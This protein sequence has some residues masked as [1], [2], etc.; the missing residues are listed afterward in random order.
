MKSLKAG[1]VKLYDANPETLNALSGTKL[2]VSIMVPN[3][4][5][6]KI[7]SNQS[8]A[9][10][11]VQNNVVPFYPAT[12]IRFLLVGNEILSYF[13]DQDKQTWL[14]L[15][16]A[17]YR[18]RSALRS[19][20]IRKIKVGTPLAMDVLQSS[21]P[22]S[23][24]TF[25]NDISSVVMEPLLRFLSQSQSFFFLDAYPYF[26][27]SASPGDISL[28]Y[29]L[30][31][32]GNFT[33]TDP[34]SRLTYTNLFDQMLDSVN[35]AMTRLGFS[36]IGL[37]ISETGWPTAGDIEQIGANIYN[38]AT[39]NRN[40]IRRM[41]AKAP[42]GTPARP[43]T[44]I[45]TFIFS[46][47]NENQK[48]GAG[49]E[50]NWGLLY[51]DG[52][53]V[54]DVDLSGKQPDYT[55]K[56]LPEP[57]NNKPY[58]GNIWC[59]V[60]NEVIRSNVS[61]LRSAMM[62]AC[63]QGNGTCD[64]LEA[65]KECSEGASLGLSVSYA[66]S[67]YWA[68]FRSSGVNCF[69]NGLAVQT[70]RDP[71]EH[72]S[73]RIGINYG[74][75]GNNLP[76]PSKSVQLLKSLK[77]NRVK[78]YDANP[79]ILKSLSGT[80]IQVSIMV[81]NQEISN[82]SSNQTL[83]DKWVQ[84]NV[85]PFYLETMIRF[86]L[87]GN[88]ILSQNS[89]QDKQTWLD[90]V[91]AMYRI[92]QALRSHNILKIKVGTPLAMDVLQ[93]SFPPSSGT[94]RSDISQ[95][96]V[97][98]LLRFLNR[99]RSFFFLDA[100]PYFPW[101]ASPSDISLDYALF[102]GNIT[103]TDP[104]S[105]LTYTNLFDQ[106]LDSVNFAITRLGFSDIRLVIAET[107]WPT[108]GYVEEIGANIY[109]AATYNRNLIRRMT[110]K[111]QIG[112][113][114]RPGIV[115]P[116]FIFSLYNENQKG[117]PGTERH[118]GLLYPNGTNVYHA[119]L[120][121]KQLEYDYKSLPAPTNNKPYKGK[122]WCVVN[123]EVIK[124]NTS[125]LRSAID[126]ACGQGNGTC[127][128]L[129]PGKE[130]RKVVSLELRASYVFSSYWAKFRSV[131]GTC[132]FNGL[133]VQTTTDPNADISS[134]IGVD[135]GQLGNNLPSP[136]RSVQLLKSLKAGRVK[137]YDANPKILK[138]LSG[139]K[140]QVSIMVPNQEISNISSSQTLADKW[141]Q[142]NV[143]PFYPETMIRFLLVGNEIL[144]YYSDQDKQ[145]WFN[146]VPAMYRIRQALRSH[147]IHKIKVGTP[148]AMDVLQSSFPPSN[149]TF[150]DDI[151]RLV[152]EPLLRFLH[153]T[154]SYFFLDAYPYFPWLANPGDISLDY[155]LFTGGNI[156]Y[157][158]SGSNL[159][160]TNL[161][162]QM[163]DSVNFAM[164]R[165]GFPGIRLVIAETGWPTVGDVEQIG[166]N[167]YNA[168]VYNR[169]LIRI[170]TSKPPIGTPA[171]PGIVIPTFIFSLYNE[172]QKG[173]QETERHWGLLYPN[174]TNVYEVDLSG[175]QLEY[176]YKLLP[177]PTNNKPNNY[178]YHGKIWC[179]V[180][181][182]FIR[183]NN[184]DLRSAMAYA[185][186]QGNGTCDA[187]QP[188]KEC[189]EVLSFELRVSYSFSSYWAKFRRLG[190]T[191]YFEGLAVQTTTDPSKLSS[192]SFLL[193]TNY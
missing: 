156:T 149:G 100:Y 7:S 15:V 189:G 44:V 131:G 183:S 162:D 104:G 40:L 95:P 128:A 150:R 106:M 18:I 52:T 57:M 133:A 111:P 167:I 132:Y 161:L 105:N 3:Q 51:P 124:S 172:N 36:D 158:D 65:G 169:H 135:Y 93:S 109:N 60:N 92:K 180:K 28:D 141:V 62:Y 138:S 25:R 193:D 43:R 121:G 175:K 80:K 177:A 185:C 38:A 188:G 186:S 103:Y 127:D 97:K 136:S 84:I 11:W 73:S 155:A 146:L 117:G 6:S 19:H 59:V 98:P 27:W 181:N 174:G 148:L 5:I 143:V 119:D 66:F 116:T 77:A 168:A 72:I 4:E 145:T 41:T 192:L 82:I 178:L 126:Y 33:Y 147:N 160:Y 70:T 91:P 159:T 85:V 48:G 31:R 114:A 39:Y 170:M 101:L 123:N 157:I 21:F 35:F 173:G 16:P 46:L 118:W 113:P 190:G 47:Y 151:S 8:L 69:F 17:M 10:Q 55:Y 139:T 74:Q 134:R 163:L 26:P 88:E 179:V 191:C 176:D 67:S 130:C 30:F 96:V 42:I 75:L 22:P 68:K 64:A 81:S 13:T 56:S 58:K 83:A 50:R 23:S 122:I 2:Q 49:T 108:A 112:T 110:S 79:E 37:A 166:A 9:D 125:E 71:N 76:S 89:D 45:P 32:D 54:Y 90:L 87:V 99:T 102:R 120:S 171:R 140:I 115:I 152:M 78:I 165:L 164:T 29:A 154:R 137:I 61:D 184:S 20:N 1:R 86:L 24:G 182:E 107:G 187:L 63:S 144:S 53:K 142:T 153:R 129:Q 12:M 14:D 34:G 94:F